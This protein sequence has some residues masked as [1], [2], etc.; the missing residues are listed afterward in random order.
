M[1]KSTVFTVLLLL[2]VMAAYS[3]GWFQASAEAAGQYVQLIKNDYVRLGLLSCAAS[4]LMLP[5]FLYLHYVTRSVKSMTAAF[6]KITQSH[7]SCCDFQHRKLCSRYA[8]DVK[9]LRESYK[10]IRQTYVMGAVLCQV[11]VF[12]Y[13]FEVVKSTP[14]S[15]NAPPAVTKG[16]AIVLIIYLLFYMRSYLLQLLQ[17]GQTAKKAVVLLLAGA[18]IWWM[19]SF[20]MSELLFLI[21]LAVIQQ[22]GSFI[23]KRVSYRS[24]ASLDL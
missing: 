8:G 23:Y 10:G 18:G 15:F 1:K 16:L 7:Q 3:F 12:G 2:M 13:M 17:N 5:A 22:I 24:S 4:V 20:T 11:I 21:I 14:I 9:S 6:Q 19:L